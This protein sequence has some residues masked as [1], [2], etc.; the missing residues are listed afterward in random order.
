MLTITQIIYSLLVALVRCTLLLPLFWLSRNDWVKHNFKCILL[1][2][3][4][5]VASQ[6][7][8][9]SLQDI[10]FFDGQVWN[11][12]GKA[13]E[14][15]LGLLFIYTAGILTKKEAG[16][17]VNIRHPKKI[18]AFIALLLLISFSIQYSLYGFKTLKSTETFWFELFVPGITEELIFRGVLLG[19]LNKAYKSRVMVWQTSIGWG[20][21]IT[22]VLFGLVH[23]L[24]FDGHAIDFKMLYFIN[25]CTVGLLLA[26]IKEKSQ[27]LL[28]GMLYH[29]LLNLV[30]TYV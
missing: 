18:A 19:L 11:W 22:A 7:I 3:V 2:F 24:K 23:A 25:S 8:V 29:N 6:V 17:T 28:P 20:L 13:G 16:W 1:F 5:F 10:T 4:L 14:L 15:L 27:S 9:Y 26:F 21:V 30:I 12:A